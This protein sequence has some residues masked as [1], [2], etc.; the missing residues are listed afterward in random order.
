MYLFRNF[1]DGSP[2]Q[3]GGGGQ[4]QF[5]S[6]KFICILMHSSFSMNFSFFIVV[7]NNL[8][9]PCSILIKYT[10]LSDVLSDLL[11]KDHEIRIYSSNACYINLFHLLQSVGNKVTLKLPPQFIHL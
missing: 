9:N 10:L 6:N 8:D 4:W 1:W 5:P 3:K 2:P 11:K 7:Y